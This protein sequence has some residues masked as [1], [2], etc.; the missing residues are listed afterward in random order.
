MQRFH[1]PNWKQQSSSL[2]YTQ[3]KTFRYTHEIMG[4]I[5]PTFRNSFRYHI[6]S[7]VETGNYDLQISNVTSDDNGV[8]RCSYVTEN[9]TGN[10][11]LMQRFHDPNWK[12]QSSSLEYTQNKTF[13]YTHEIMGFFSS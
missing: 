12:Q 6:D 5:N 11:P 10:N 4:F 9:K 1:D 13:R 2:E 7:D 3:N 8:Y